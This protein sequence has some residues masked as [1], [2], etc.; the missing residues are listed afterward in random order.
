VEVVPPVVLLVG[1]RLRRLAEHE[2]QVLGHPGPP[3]YS[4]AAG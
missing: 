1:D 3:V 4:A 2:V